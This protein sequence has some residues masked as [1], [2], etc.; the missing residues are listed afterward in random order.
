MVISDFKFA[1]IP[2]IYF[3]PGKINLLAD[4]AGQY[5]SK[6][7]LVTGSQSLK[8]SGKLDII[9]KILKSANMEYF[10]T[11]VNGEPTPEFVDKTVDDFRNKEIDV[12]LA[13]GGGSVVDAGK[14]VSA[15]FL[16]EGSIIDYLEDVGTKKHPGKKIPFIAVST[17]AGTGSE[18]TKNAVI[19]RVAKYGFKKSLRHDNFVPDIAIIDPEL[20]LDCP[21]DVT[22]ACGM[23]AFTQLL[24]AYLSTNASPMTDAL[25]FSGLEYA[26]KNLPVVCDKETCKIEAR[27]GMAYAALMSGICLANAGLGIVHGFASP[28]GGYFDIPH[29]V[30]CGTLV[31]EATKMNITR[32]KEDLDKNVLYLQKYANVGC[33]MG[34]DSCPDINNNCNALIEKLFKWT[35]IFDLPR[36]GPYGIG[37]QDVKKIVESSSMKYNPVNLNKKDL[38]EILI[39]RL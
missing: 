6:V 32:L 34:D 31:G 29:G 10:I 15:M 7:L 18:A 27:S 2:D 19:R 25:A 4:L 36:L 35:E 14:A 13:I 8:Q 26:V 12:V 17:T 5:G 16:L 22:V 30:V 11:S 37:D 24:E 20:A 9:L 23:D 3:G 21:Y 38:R 33:L 39:N 1:R 28:I